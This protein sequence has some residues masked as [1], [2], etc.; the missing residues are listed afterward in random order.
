MDL[1]VCGKAACAGISPE[2]NVQ[3][4]GLE[5]N[6]GFSAK[7]FQHEAVIDVQTSSA[8]NSHS[9]HAYFSVL[10]LVGV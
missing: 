4:V 9:R 8:E 6:I 3:Q 10:D 7:T 5:Q 2:R 1:Y